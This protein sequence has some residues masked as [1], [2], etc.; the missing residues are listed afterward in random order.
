LAAR[1]FRPL[2][3]PVG[4]GDGGKDSADRLMPPQ[5]A[6]MSCYSVAEEITPVCADFV[7]ERRGFEPVTSAARV[8]TLVDGAA[9]S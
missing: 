9:A 4:R 7:V 1:D 2:A 5:A 3:P 6:G 8:A